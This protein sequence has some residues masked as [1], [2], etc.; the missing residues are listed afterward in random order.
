MGLKRV[1]SD[2]LSFLGELCALKEGVNKTPRYGVVQ[3]PYDA[4]TSY[5]SGASKG[6]RAVID[7]SAYVEFYDSEFD[8]EPYE[9]GII[10][11][12]PLDILSDTPEVMVESVCRAVGEVVAGE[13]IPV[14]LGGEHSVTLGAVKALKEKYKDLSVLQLDAHA[15]MR[16]S[17]NGSLFNHACAARRISELSPITQVGVRS[18]SIEEAE[19]LKNHN[20]KPFNIDTFYACDAVGKMD[21]AAITETLREDVFITIDLDVLDPS[22]MP[23]TGTPEP[24]GLMWYETLELLRHVTKEKN[25]VGFDVVELSPIAGMVAPDFLAARLVYK[26]M[27]YIN[28]SVD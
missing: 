6:P 25:V 21:F 12:E 4:T 19:F 17:Y 16:E 10:T 9:A 28:N 23:A 15:D 24:G 26:L 7:A 8:C 13:M 22:I 27:A 20:G 1:G 11:F 2:T 14:I 3:A 5:V 18:M